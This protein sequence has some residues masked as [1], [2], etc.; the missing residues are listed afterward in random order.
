M[1]DSPEERKNLIIRKRTIILRRNPYGY[2][3]V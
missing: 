3:L 1:G 2:E